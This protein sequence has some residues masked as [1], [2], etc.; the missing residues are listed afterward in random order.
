M[1]RTILVAAALIAPALCVSPALAQKES[2]QGDGKVGAYEP[3]FPTKMTWVLSSIN[4]KPGAAEATLFID[5]TLRGSGNA[6]CNTWSA[7]LYPIRGKKLAMG[8][9]AMTKKACPAPLMAFERAYLSV[10]ATGP[11]WDLAGSTLT[12]K[13]KA[14]TL[15]F[16]RGL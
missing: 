8:P 2:K 4:G 3:P 10:L 15:V 14:G 13:S 11:S 16:N 7:T 9:V 6:G 12:V 5:E 1:K